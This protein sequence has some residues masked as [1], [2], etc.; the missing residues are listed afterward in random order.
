MA[1]HRLGWTAR[2]RSLRSRR[3]AFEHLDARELLATL[4]VGV[5]QTF[6]TIQAA[7][8]N[9]RPNDVIQIASTG[10]GSAYSESI[11]LSLMGSAVA[12]APGSLTIRGSTTDTT[13]ITS[14]G[15]AVFFNS[16]AFTGDLRFEN[17]SLKAPVDTGAIDAGIRLSSYTGGLTISKVIVTDAVDVGIQVVNSSGNLNIDDVDI[18]TENIA[19]PIGIHF[20]NYAANGNVQDVNISD[21]TD[22]TF[23]VE[24]GGTTQSNLMLISVSS[25]KTSASEFAAND[26]LRVD[27]SGSGRLDIGMASSFFDDLPAN[28]ID[29]TVRDNATA[30]A[31]F[32]DSVNVAT[33]EGTPRTANEPAVRFVTRNSAKLGLAYEINNFFSVPGDNLTIQG[34]NT[35]TINATVHDNFFLNPGLATGDDSITITGD[36]SSAATINVLVSQSTILT[37]FG[38]GV[39]VLANGSARYNIVLHENS[40]IYTTPGSVTDPRTFAQ[41]ASGIDVTAPSQSTAIVS[42]RIAQ[43]NSVETP[44]AP[45]GSSAQAVRIVKAAGTIRVE[46]NSSGNGGISTYLL[47]QN[48]IKAPS[49][50]GA[51]DR[52][53][54]D[55]VLPNM[56]LVIGDRVWDDAD[57]NGLL[58]NLETGKAGSMLTLSG[59]ETVSGAAVTR[60]TWTDSEG[61]FL[62]GGLLPG[63]YSVTLSARAGF[64][65]TSLKRGNGA[66]PE[67]DS[68]FRQGIRTAS[69]TLTNGVPNRDLDAG[70]VPTDG[71]IWKNQII[72]ED[73]DDNGAVTPLD[74]LLVIIDLN[75]NGPRVLAAPTASFTPQP[76]LDVDGNGVVAP[77]D[78]LLVIIRLNSGGGGEPPAADFT[79]VASYT[80]TSSKSESSD[81]ESATPPTASAS[82]ASMYLP[83]EFY[84]P[85]GS[86]NQASSDDDETNPLDAFFAGIGES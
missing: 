52:I 71:K 16:A 81:E 65:L 21:T 1:S 7:V 29:F 61:R 24:V 25:A 67:T 28:S 45:D 63:T 55:A 50:S 42:L 56:P 78:A 57:K 17:L 58:N 9:A 26:G 11:N 38:N 48:S 64:D 35:S 84:S 59:I 69:V 22:A 32:H 8:N 82:A 34:L 6:T 60:T 36:N 77:T 15:G 41:G 51:L 37:P 19:T 4:N 83:P 5:G 79:P 44:T 30:H 2:G 43:Q 40:I 68:D 49:I 47:S 73:I 14:P 85:V 46:S 27:V 62:L 33:S 39:T 53:F 70:L 66:N 31:S 3:L 86:N 76:F 12:S 72:A 20:A 80:T 18:N 13:A 10:A 74:A 54:V 23:F 75:A